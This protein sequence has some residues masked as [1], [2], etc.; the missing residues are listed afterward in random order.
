MADLNALRGPNDEKAN[1][2]LDVYHHSM[3]LMLDGVLYTAP[4]D[5][6]KCENVLDIGTGTGKLAHLLYLEE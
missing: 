4:I 5:G 2:L 1:S 6:E 3:T